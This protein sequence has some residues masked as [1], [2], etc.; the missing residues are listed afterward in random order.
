MLSNVISKRSVFFDLLAAH[1]SRLVAGA[2][3]TLRLITGLGQDAETTLDLIEEVHQNETSADKIKADLIR[4]LYQSFTT[5]INRDQ[6]HTLTLDLDRVLDDLQHVANAIGAYHIDTATIEARAMASLS[7][8]ACM[9]LHHAVVA[10]ADKD[11]GQE[12]IDLCKEIDL[13]ES[14]VEDLRQK[15]IKKLFED[16]GEDPAVWHAIKMLELYSLLETV[17]DSSKRA[18]KTIEEILLENT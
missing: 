16:E 8:D 9:R 5:P 12:I 4:Q 18:A 17:L 6:L 2:N 3:A 10:L 15:A 13:L 1:T 11:R 7:A 14:A